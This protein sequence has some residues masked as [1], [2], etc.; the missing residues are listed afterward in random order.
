METAYMPLFRNRRLAQTSCKS[1]RA[2]NGNKLYFEIHMDVYNKRQ[3]SLICRRSI[4]ERTHTVH[5]FDSLDSFLVSCGY[6]QTSP[7]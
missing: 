2:N 6:Q 1:S 3:I 7:Q 4:F 5:L